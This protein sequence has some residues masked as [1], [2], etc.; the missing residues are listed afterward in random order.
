MKEE[1]KNCYNCRYYLRH[2][3]KSKTR[4]APLYEGHCIHDSRISKPKGRKQIISDCA[5]WE[6]VKIQ[7]EERKKSICAVL[8]DMEET[9]EV[10]KMI[11]QSDRED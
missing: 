6:T 10:I 7:K 2:Y 9:L 4:L 1:N 3:A 11:L 5:F 8:R